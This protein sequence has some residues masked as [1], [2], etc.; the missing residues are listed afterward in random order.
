MKLDVQSI[1]FKNFFS[2]GNNWNKLDI[3][4][5]VNLIMGHDESKGRSNGSGKSS[6]FETIP[7]ALFGKVAKEVKKADI[8]NWINKKNC[9]VK[10]TFAI[11]TDTYTI[12]RA[13]KPDKLEIYKNNILIP[14][15]SLI[16]D[17]QLML[18]DDILHMDVKSF[19]ALIYTNLNNN[20]PLLKMSVPDRRSFLERIF[21]LETYNEINKKATEKIRTIEEKI[22]KLETNID[23]S[24]TLLVELNEQNT[25][26][27]KRLS[28]IIIPKDELD[29][30]IKLLN[31][32]INEITDSVDTEG[33]KKEI[34][35]VKKLIQ[36]YE[37]E[38][39]TL[40]A[41]I[42]GLTNEFNT[43]QK[44]VDDFKESQASKDKIWKEYLDELDTLN[45]EKMPN[46]DTAE[47]IVVEI[48]K[49]IIEIK[50]S[51]SDRK[52]QKATLVERLR[53]IIESY[54][55]LKNGICPTC[56]TELTDECIQE[57]YTDK[58]Q[59]LND[60]IEELNTFI[61]QSNDEL[62][63]NET[64]ELKY[65]DWVKK[66]TK[67]N[68]RI[69]VLTDNIER[70]KNEKPSI[71]IDRF[72]KVLGQNKSEIE[73]RQARQSE[74]RNEIDGLI[75]YKLKEAND[76]LTKYIDDHENIR[77]CREKITLLTNDVNSKQE[78]YD[79]LY[80]LMID[81]EKKIK[82]LDLQVNKDLINMNKI[83]GL[84]DYLNYIKV[85]C[86]DDNVKQYAISS[87]MPYLTQRTNHYLAE[88]GIGYYLKFDKWAEAT[89]YGP[90][91]VGAS[92]NNLCGGESKSIDLS[93]QLAFLDIA[94][95]KAGVFPNILL[96]DELLDSSVD[97]IGLTN[98]LRIIKA[99][100]MEDN[101]KIFIIS[102]RKEV[103]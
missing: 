7:F 74:I 96:L 89:I 68:A 32:L 17:Y 81:N 38:L 91:I 65:K 23:Q 99:K 85:L 2:Y 25:N 10:L 80:T 88:S 71:D 98:V 87:N 16:R 56:K 50:K 8:V 39:G 45:A 26:L 40:D 95:I 103:D 69:Q 12:L 34:N 46:L 28:S 102:H 14:I 57:H 42:K 51:L 62:K 21:N 6:C 55:Q 52:I 1:E 83:K 73:N 70:L 66:I 82:D 78:L 15:P 48:T 3:L 58:I 22:Y 29:R 79:E 30:Y 13:I 63:E 5:G 35:D 4:P 54:E 60:S 101:N 86:K 72:I 53:T 20:V 49:N 47:N 76:K 19:M 59:N 31:T 44:I 33:L 67:R 97:A 61:T 24:K 11:N 75:T 100:Q 94:K 9:E 77:K 92:Y 84:L 36:E 43:A 93:V 37:I 18:E 41:Q 64:K 90:G 27:N